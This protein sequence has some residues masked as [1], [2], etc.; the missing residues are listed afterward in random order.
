MNPNKNIKKGGDMRKEIDFINKKKTFSKVRKQKV[1]REIET[2]T[3]PKHLEMKEFWNNLR[4]NEK[5]Y[6]SSSEWIKNTGRK[7]KKM[8]SKGTT[9]TFT[10]NALQTKKKDKKMQI[11]WNRYQTSD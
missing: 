8:T 3:K 11:P 10:T 2:S 5:I 7:N 9:S 1:Y 6:K 4:G